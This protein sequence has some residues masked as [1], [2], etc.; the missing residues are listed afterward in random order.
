MMI[1]KSDNKPVRLSE[2]NKALV[3]LFVEGFILKLCAVLKSAF[4]RLLFS[5]IA[6]AKLELL[7]TVSVRLV[8]TKSVSSIEQFSKLVFLRLSL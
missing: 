7:K 6:P 5:K 1:L 3:I 8:S 2:A 4:S